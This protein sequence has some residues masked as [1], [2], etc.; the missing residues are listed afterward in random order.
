MI[1][2]HTH[3]NYSDGTWN[4][5]EL[6]ENAEKANIEILSI[7]DH[8]SVKSHLELKSIG[9]KKYFRGKIISG[10]EIN[11]I[12]NNSKIELLGYGF[13]IEPVNE[14]LE[15][16]YN[17][18]KML[19]KRTKEFKDMCRLCRKK[20]IKLT[21]G[22]KCNH[23]IE[24]PIDKIYYDAIKH[25]ENEKFFTEKEWANSDA[26]YRNCS[27]NKK[28]MLYRDFSKDLP[29]AKEVS[30][31]IKRNGGKVFLAHLYLYTLGNYIEFLEKLNDKKIIDGVETYYFS[32]TKEQSDSIKNFCEEKGILMSI[33]SDCHGL[34][35]AYR[36]IGMANYYNP[37]NLN[38]IKEW[39][40]K[41][42]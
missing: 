6:L 23:D 3:T 10:V 29:S 24:Y 39:I 22:L 41:L 4:V 15:K 7:T 16:K 11:C 36:K 13:R 28:F 25:P 38:K 8:D 42:S 35:K 27:S 40:C 19:K 2:L 31:V 1:D 37:L 12:F 9:T 20:G 21:E 33:G 14:W 34:K 26:F 32:F 30:K 18:E 17:K 5:Q